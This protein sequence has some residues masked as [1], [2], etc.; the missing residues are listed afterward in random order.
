M[1]IE[2]PETIGQWIEETF[3]GGDPASPRKS[4]RLME[5]VAELCKACGATQAEVIVATESAFRGMGLHHRHPEPENVP[6]EAADCNIV[7]CG[8]AKLNGFS[9]GDAT[10]SKMIVNR[11]R[12]WKANMDGTG[13][14]IREEQS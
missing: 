12:K 9:L 2:T 5:E 14:H 11:S 13:Y 1:S 6:A 4:L 8:L 10:D 7:L 3:P